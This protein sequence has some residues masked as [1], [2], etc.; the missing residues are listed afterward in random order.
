[1]EALS[2]PP[3]PNQALREAFA[4]RVPVETRLTAEQWLTR[5]CAERGVGTKGMFTFKGTCDLAEAF[6]DK[7]DVG[8]A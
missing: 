4:N 3:S 8:V 2:N 7:S 6:R 1:M 5:F